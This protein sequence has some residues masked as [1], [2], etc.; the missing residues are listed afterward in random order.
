MGDRI[1]IPI[2]N[3]QKNHKTLKNIKKYNHSSKYYIS[4]YNTSKKSSKPTYISTKNIKDKLKML[5][6]VVYIDENKNSNQEV[7]FIP[8]DEN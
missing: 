4:T 5:D 8:L 3:K 2:K 6:E 7:I 1:V